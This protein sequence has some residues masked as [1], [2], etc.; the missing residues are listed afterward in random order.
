MISIE[1]PVVHGKYLNE[2]FESIRSQT[3]QDFEVIIT[4]SGGEEISDLIKQYGFKEVKA[5]TRLLNARYLAHLE[6]KGEF[7]LI[8]DETRTLR[9]DALSVL[10]ALNHDM[11]IIGE[12]E[13]GN[14]FWLKLANLDKENILE[15]NSIDTVKGFLIPRFFRREILDKAF[16]RLKENLKDKFDKVIF[17]EDFLRYYE[18]RKESD[19]VFLLKDKLIFHYGDATLFQI[20]KKY[21]RYGKNTKMLKGTPYHN[22]VSINRTKRNICLG[23]KILL[24]LLYLARGIPFLIGYLLL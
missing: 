10:S 6:S 8:L 24:Y 13:I 1:I 16:N 11:V 21:H 3:Y 9:R 19:D 4:S 18:A 17:R 7:S 2:V 15:C 14:T 12:Q 5:I 22:L 20:I 23:N